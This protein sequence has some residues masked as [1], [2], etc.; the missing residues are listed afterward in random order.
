MAVLDFALAAKMDEEMF[1][2][3]TTST[4]RPGTMSTFRKKT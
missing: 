4:L 1:D 2:R 3:M